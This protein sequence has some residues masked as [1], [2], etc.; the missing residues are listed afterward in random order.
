MRLTLKCVNVLI[1]LVERCCYN[2][3]PQEGDVTQTLQDHFNNGNIYNTY[4]L[5][6]TKNLL[7][8]LLMHKVIADSKIYMHKQFYQKM[9]IQ[10]VTY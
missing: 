6:T 3:R 1:Y 7:G 8:L 4:T 9:L 10:R 2:L 5:Y